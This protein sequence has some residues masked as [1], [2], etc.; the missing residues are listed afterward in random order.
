MNKKIS[1]YK[2]GHGY[3]SLLSGNY[4]VFIGQDVDNRLMFYSEFRQDARY[5]SIREARRSFDAC[6]S[7]GPDETGYAKG[8]PLLQYGVTA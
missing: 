6:M 4:Y 8:L 1:G 5:L 7:E 3:I 2:T